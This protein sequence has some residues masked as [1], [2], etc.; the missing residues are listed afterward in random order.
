MSVFASEKVPASYS[1][2]LAL[3]GSSSDQVAVWAIIGCMLF[4][5]VVFVVVFV[6]RVRHFHRTRYVTRQQ[7]Q[8]DATSSHRA[9]HARLTR[10]CN[11]RWNGQG[12]GAASAGGL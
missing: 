7:Q 5:A 12:D 2:G 8:R 3:V 10:P 11:G 6:Y 9:V 1:V 4:V